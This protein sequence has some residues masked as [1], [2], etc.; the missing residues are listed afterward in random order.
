MYTAAEKQFSDKNEGLTY[1]VE[2]AIS[3]QLLNNDALGMF[4]D[5]HIES[6]SGSNE[7]HYTLG[8]T[9]TYADALALRKELQTL[10]FPEA[11][12]MPYRHGHRITRAEA[13]K[14]L[15]QYPDLAAYLRG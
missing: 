9:R 15:K 2:V 6:I 3:R 1:K 11:K 14:Y 10:G 5:Q 8:W 12:V 13:V 4:N 7:Y